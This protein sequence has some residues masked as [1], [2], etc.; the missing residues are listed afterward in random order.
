MVHN[1]GMGNDAPALTVA[2]LEANH[3][4]NWEPALTYPLPGDPSLDLIDNAIDEVLNFLSFIT[5]EVAQK[6]APQA[7]RE[8]ERAAARL[9]ELAEAKPKAFSAWLQECDRERLLKNFDS[10]TQQ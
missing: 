5:S 7:R 2:I 8:I 4:N 9:I 3:Y 1:S 6:D 10:P